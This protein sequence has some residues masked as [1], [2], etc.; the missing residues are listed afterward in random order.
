MWAKKKIDNQTNESNEEMALEN[1]ILE[2]KTWEN[3]ASEWSDQ[4]DSLLGKIKEAIEKK[5]M[6]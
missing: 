3:E 5:K 6:N 1:N 2:L 4:I